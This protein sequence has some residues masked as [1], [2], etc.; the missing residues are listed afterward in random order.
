MWF[1][2][3]GPAE[4]RGEGILSAVYH[5]LIRTFGIARE[6]NGD[7]WLNWHRCF[8]EERRYFGV[9]VHR[10]REVR[11]VSSLS[12]VHH[13]L[14]ERPSGGRNGANRD[15]LTCREVVH[16]DG[17]SVVPPPPSG[18]ESVTVYVVGFAGWT[19]SWNVTELFRSPDVPTTVI[20]K[21]PG[22]AEVEVF[23]RRRDTKL[24]VPYR[25]CE[26]CRHS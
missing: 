4:A 26:R 10:E 15:E 16:S 7:Y 25:R 24:A 14:A 11:A 17:G 19:V 9:R 3:T 12:A 13:P 21:I 20:W 6:R 1:E 22:P 18:T 8:R 5:N 23:K 2:P